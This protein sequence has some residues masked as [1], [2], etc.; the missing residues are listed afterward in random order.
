[1]NTYD[2]VNLALG[3]SVKLPIHFQNEHANRFASNV[4]GIKLGFMLSHPRVLSVAVDEFK[5][6]L[7]IKAYGSGD[8]NIL[9]YM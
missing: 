3:S 8:C 6:E 4:E 5:Q 1:M 9:V 7:T 2:S